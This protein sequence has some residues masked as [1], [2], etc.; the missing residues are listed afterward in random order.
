MG[1]QASKG[2]AAAVVIVVSSS[3]RKQ[4]YQD[5]QVRCVLVGVTGGQHC[6]EQRAGGMGVPRG[7]MGHNSDNNTAFVCITSGHARGGGGTVLVSVSR[8]PYG[9]LAF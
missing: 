1:G 7:V 9:S 4:E 5:F 3:G 6:G 2:K 8:G